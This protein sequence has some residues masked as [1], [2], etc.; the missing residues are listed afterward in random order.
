MSLFVYLICAVIAIITLLY[1][2][3]K[4]NNEYFRKNG[5]IQN[6]NPTLFFG[7][8]YG[9]GFKIHIIERL[10]ELYRKFQGQDLFAGVYFMLR[11]TILAI[12]LDFVKQ[13]MIKDFSFFR[14]RGMYV[15]ERDDPMTAHLFSLDG[16]RWKEMRPKLSPTF[17]SGKMKQM[18]EIISNYSQEC[19]GL[20][21]TFSKTNEAIDVKN[22]CV[23]YI[24]DVIGLSAFG[25]ECNAMKETNSELVEMSKLL[26]I[27]SAKEQIRQMICI[28]CPDFARTIRMKLFSPV[29]TDYFMGILKQ[30]VSHREESKEERNDFLNILIK[31]KNLGRASEDASEYLGKITFDELAAQAFVFFFAGF[32]SSST[33][34]SFTLLELAQNQDFQNKAR[35]EVREVLKKHDGKLTYE[36]VNELHYLEQVVNGK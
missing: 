6:E 18:F 26:F 8:L 22:I 32:E 27:P 3:L 35:E 15:N 2:Y 9:V 28:S 34:M 29:L 7:D 13:I 17:T 12:D 11:P 30:T 31:I 36:A 10:I 19:V 16:E 24:A 25:L 23:R 14:D 20:F 5:I 1:V 4:R 33:A 21:D